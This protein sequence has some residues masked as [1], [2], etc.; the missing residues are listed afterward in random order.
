MVGQG[1]VKTKVCWLWAF[2]LPRASWG[3]DLGLAELAES[4]VLDLGKAGC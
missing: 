3:R 4:E 1:L 2:L